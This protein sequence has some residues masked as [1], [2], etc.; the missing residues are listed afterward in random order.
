[1]I[2]LSRIEAGDSLT[3]NKRYANSLSENVY[4]NTMKRLLQA[5]MREKILGFKMQD[6]D[7]IL[8]LP[9]ISK[10]LLIKNIA[11]ASLNRFIGYPQLYLLEAASQHII[12]DPVDLLL[13]LSNELSHTTKI[14]QWQVFS[15][16][17]VNH[18]QN[19]HHSNLALTKYNREIR[20]DALNKGVT[21]LVDWLNSHSKLID[22]NIFFEQIVSQG[23]P[24]HPCSKTKLD[25]S[26]Q[27]L[28]QYAPEFQPEVKLPIVAIKKEYVHVESNLSLD[29]S[30]WFEKNYF[31]GF[32]TF[33]SDLINKKL[34]PDEYL[35]LPVHPWQ[36]T[37]KIPSLFTDLIQ[38]KILVL[39]PN[40]I[41]KATPTLSFRSLAPTD[42]PKS[43]YIKL[44][45]A[46]QATS[47]LRTL[48]PRST[49]N[50][51]RISALITKILFQENGFNHRLKILSENY[52]LHIKDLDKNKS[53]HLSVIFRENV[54]IK[55]A[56]SELCVVVAALLEESPI[57]GCKLLIEF[58]N[59]AGVEGLEPAVKYFTRYV[60]LILGSYLDLYLLYGISLEGHQ[61]NTLA[62]FEKGYI[63][64]FIARDVDGTDIHAPSL[65]EKKLNLEL[66]HDSTI[67]TDNRTNV[68]N[69][70][71]HAVYQC[72]LSE[73]VLLLAN[74]F[75]CK[76]AIFWRVVKNITL[77]RF[78]TIK[79]QMDDSTWQEDYDAILNQ[80][81]QCKA[82]MRMRLLGK[83]YSH[84][85]Y[86]NLPN[87]LRELQ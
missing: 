53:K 23:H 28:M 18:M 60:D 26:P 13:L 17:V 24:H 29:Y 56:D 66:H 62:V 85:Q 2:A 73:I 33:R 11:L 16:E 9:D 54:E 20:Q 55:L 41:I 82:L 80:E 35:P 25:L 67:L 79:G 57:S 38:K 47:I 30:V 59:S 5:V 84:G 43:A 32:Q 61:Q 77:Q 65:R 51:P 70:F 75:K 86:L 40:A 58:M 37:K 27:E 6:N 81:W 8:L 3:A 36:I 69:D 68:R 76:E 10:K 44:P 78:N 34:D 1:M 63:K 45:V 7:I 12:E 83:E 21:N 46:I 52:G 74:H 72:H 50:G 39:L 4:A 22:K 71:L 14:E 42:N 64:Y 19:A 15:Q 31:V 49:V 87:P 48:L